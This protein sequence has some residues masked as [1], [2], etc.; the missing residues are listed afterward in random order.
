M[1]KKSEEAATNN[2][3]LALFRIILWNKYYRKLV[4]YMLKSSFIF[5]RTS[6][7]SLKLF[8]YLVKENSVRSYLFPWNSL[9]G[10]PLHRWNM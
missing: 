3:K 9:I 8:R 4:V 7:T 6:F 1:K 2:V 10:I 5:T